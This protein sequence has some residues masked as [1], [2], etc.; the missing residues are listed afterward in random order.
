M[1]D[2][3]SINAEANVDELV[4]RY[5]R[6]ARVF[7]RHHMACVGCEI[8]RFESI[9]EVCAIYHL[10]LE[11]ALAEIREAASG[12]SHGPNNRTAFG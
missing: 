9:A 12:V 5:P 3:I 11:A 4:R 6:T 8:A 7:L 1:N 2:V 10:P